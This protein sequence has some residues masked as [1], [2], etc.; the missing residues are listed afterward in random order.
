MQMKAM[1]NWEYIIGGPDVTKRPIV[2]TT[3]ELVELGFKTYASPTT[4]GG[5]FFNEAGATGA[6][7]DNLEVYEAWMVTFNSNGGSDVE[8]TQYVVL[9]KSHRTI[10]SDKRKR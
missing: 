5:V 9:I 2:K 4:T 8:A 3:W 10:S 1:F 7:I 6:Y